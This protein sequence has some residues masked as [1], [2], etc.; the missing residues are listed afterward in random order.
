MNLVGKKALVTGGSRG[1]GRAIANLLFNRG[2][3]VAICARGIYDLNKAITEMAMGGNPDL[4]RMFLIQIIQADLLTNDGVARVIE[5][6]L[7]VDI[8][9]NN[10]GG[11]GRWG[12]DTDLGLDY[13]VFSDVM[14]KN[15]NATA[16]ITLV[17]LPHM[18]ENG[19]GRVVTISSI[20]GI[21][22]TI[23]R[24]A[25]MTAKAAQI[26]FS[27]GLSRLSVIAKNGVTI[28]AV[29]PGVT[30]VGKEIVDHR[31]DS[32]PAG[33]FGKPEDI[34]NL[35][36]FLCSDEASHINGACITVDG[37]ESV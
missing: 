10:C 28:N 9:I 34:A 7:P 19:W 22:A 16:E 30:D 24:P 26:A 25:F 2:C 18:I 8:L 33:R 1:I 36:T 37:G 11:G 31:Q 5:H 15:I 32:I 29:C 3:R 14:Q 35:V 20:Y 21:N 12:T 27:K 23:N 13:Q 17:A 4:G 6:A